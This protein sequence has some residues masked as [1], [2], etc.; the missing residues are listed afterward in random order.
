MASIL[1]KA[2]N[3]KKVPFKVLGSEAHINDPF[4]P[5]PQ[6]LKPVPQTSE[7]SPD[8]ITN[9]PRQM[10]VP[11]PEA[12]PYLEGKYRPPSI[13]LNA[14]YYPYN[15]YLQKGKIYW[16][17]SCGLAALNPWCD[18]TCN[19]VTT[20]NRPIYFNVNE[21]GYYKMCNC[22]MSSNAPF[23]NGTHKDVVKF[24]IKSHRG[25]VEFMGQFLYFFTFGYMIWNFYT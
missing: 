4:T 3:Y 24:H 9:F 15:V 5:P 23:C 21:S 16:F 7:K 6:I 25:R 22:K 8:D 17:C 14:G 12:I 18:N 13:P 2:L 20:R 19:R 1:K 10:T 11:L